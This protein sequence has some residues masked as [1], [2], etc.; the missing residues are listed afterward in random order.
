MH[1]DAAQIA[2]LIRKKAIIHYRHRRVSRGW[3][4][5]T[6]WHICR[7]GGTHRMFCFVALCTEPLHHFAYH[8]NTYLLQN[9]CRPNLGRLSQPK[10][11]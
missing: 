2:S 5:L 11:L 7:R 10:G 6:A 9:G 4:C 1:S 8:R 3:A